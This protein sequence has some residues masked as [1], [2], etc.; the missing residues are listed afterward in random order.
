MLGAGGWVS[1][2]NGGGWGFVRGGKGKGGREGKRGR[3]KTL[4]A[5]DDGWYS[6]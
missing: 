6:T 5:D 1:E 3:E 2:E 4:G